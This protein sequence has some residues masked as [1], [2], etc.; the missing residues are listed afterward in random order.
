MGGIMKHLLIA[1]L[2]LGL[3]P[4]AAL[5]ETFQEGK[6][7]KRIVPSIPKESGNKHEVVELFWYGCPH[8]YNME[9]PLN[10]WLK[11]KPENVVFRRIPAIFNNPNW[12]FHAQVFYTAE[13]LE[14]LD[15][16]HTPLF[17]YIHELKKPLNTVDKAAEFFKS[18]GVDRKTFDKAWKSFAVHTKVNRARELTKRYNIDGVPAMVVNGQ[19]LVTNSLAGGTPKHTLKVVEY[20]TKK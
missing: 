10:K 9:K 8:C 19:Y 18:H 2:C 20:L 1:L 5:A 7:Y 11:K 14:M 17:E 6:Q 16:L 12:K 15:K 13:A 3:L 4:T